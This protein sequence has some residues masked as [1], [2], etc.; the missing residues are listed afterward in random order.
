VLRPVPGYKYAENSKYALTFGLGVNVGGAI[1]WGSDISKKLKSSPYQCEDL[2]DLNRGLSDIEKGAAIAEPMVGDIEG[3]L[4]MLENF[5][6]SN[7]LAITGM[8]AIQSKDLGALLG[9]V[10]NFVPGMSGFKVETGAEPIKVDLKAMKV[11]VDV[12]AA[13]SETMVGLAV[14]DAKKNLKALITSKPA[15]EGPF[16]VMNYNFQTLSAVLEAEGKG[17]PESEM[18]QE[19][20]SKL[21]DMIF[22][23]R[24]T[25]SGLVARSGV[26]WR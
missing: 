23:M 5:S 4:V 3:G 26:K 6:I 11:P 2:Q 9:V 21:G 17:E 16:F 18:A 19:I 10:K 20:L 24:A 22:E 8:M 1:A 12:Y 13:R 7:P 14:G 15:S 25:S